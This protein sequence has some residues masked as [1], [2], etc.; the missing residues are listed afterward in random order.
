[1]DTL[2][3]RILIN[4]ILDELL[5]FEASQANNLFNIKFQPIVNG[6]DRSIVAMESLLRWESDVLGHVSPEL[7]I[8]CANKNNQTNRL[9]SMIMSHIIS[10][11]PIIDA[12]YKKELF[13]SIN[14]PMSMLLDL[15]VFSLFYKKCRA[16]NINSSAIVIEIT[17]S[18]P[19]DIVEVSKNIDFI[20]NMGFSVYLDDFGKGYSNLECLHNFNLTGLKLDRFL[21]EGIDDLYLRSIVEVIV[22]MCE[23]EGKTLIIEGIETKAQ[24][25]TFKNLGCKY[26]QGYYFSHPVSVKEIFNGYDFN[27]AV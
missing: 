2:T 16:S 11:K 4:E 12:H 23:N 18:I 17:E 1:M 14:V 24:L 13:F 27:M 15:N 3:E 9:H 21:S 7:I 5:L 10:A 25:D 19:A 22:S 26:F 6:E 8:D 20:R